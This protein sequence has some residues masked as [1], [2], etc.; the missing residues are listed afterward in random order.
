MM[1]NST[2]QLREIHINR[3]K[4]VDQ[5]VLDQ[6]KVFYKSAKEILPLNCILCCAE[7]NFILFAPEISVQF[8][9]KVLSTSDA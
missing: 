6:I 1:L 2:Y 9:S 5:I 8:I 7:V 4:S 3:K